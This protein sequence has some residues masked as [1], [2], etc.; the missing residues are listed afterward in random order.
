[1]LM[2]QLESTAKSLIN[3]YKI[4]DIYIKNS[5][6]NE[7]YYEMDNGYYFDV[8]YILTIEGKDFVIG[9]NVTEQEENIIDN[10]LVIND[11]EEICKNLNVT[12]E[13]E[14]ENIKDILSQGIFDIVYK[15]QSEIEQ[16][17]SECSESDSES[18]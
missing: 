7:D 4:K 1:M 12:E 2:D 11:L 9:G 15:I 3:D 5:S 6:I 10:N 16:K 18:D 14:G 17:T 8:S 13:R